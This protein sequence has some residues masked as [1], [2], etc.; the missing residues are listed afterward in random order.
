MGSCFP[1]NLS[2]EWNLNVTATIKNISS[3][4]ATFLKND[5]NKDFKKYIEFLESCTFCNFNIKWLS[6]K[7]IM[8]E[9]YL[10]QGIVLVLRY[11][12]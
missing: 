11:G 4:V 10:S 5:P 7:D 9:Q 2:Q 12:N 6:K 3:L 1:K 8:C